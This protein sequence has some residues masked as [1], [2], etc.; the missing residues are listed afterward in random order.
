MKSLRNVSPMMV[1]AAALAFVLTLAVP[2]AAPAQESPIKIGPPSPLKLPSPRHFQL[3]NGLKVVLMENHKV[4]LV[5]VEVLVRGGSVLDPAGRAGLAT[6]TA[7]MMEEGAGGRSSLEYADAVDFLG[8]SISPYAS[9]HTSGVSLFTPLSKLDSAMALFADMVLR[10]SFPEQELERLRNERLTTLVQ[11][12]D[13]PRAIASVEFNQDLYGKD[14][15]YGRTSIG[16][17]ASIRAISVADLRSFHKKI[18]TPANATVIVVGDIGVDAARN[19]LEQYFGTWEGRAPEIPA[20]SPAPQVV[21]RKIILVDK[22]GAAQS[23]IRIGRIGTDRLTPDYFPLLVMNTILGGSFSSR[24]NQNL[25]ERNGYTYG[26]GSGFD[27]R[28]SAGPFRAASAVQ[29]DVTDKALVEFMKELTAIREPVSDDELTRA[30]NYLALLYPNNFET[31]S[32]AAGQLAELTVY[33]LPDDSFNTYVSSVMA[34]TKEDVLRVARKY[35]DPDNIAIVVVGDRQKVG[36]G[37][38]ALG[39]GP[40]TDMTIDDVLGPAPATGGGR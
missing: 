30:K 2:S 19:I 36:A 28:L 27:F 24:L 32:E 6:M 7:E 29:T 23:E 5:E 39:L 21:S 15:P 35:I 33:G 10:P 4:P 13:Q 11:W 12:H 17:E 38:S 14:H 34:V 37:I 3:G 16:D 1:V 22:P 8:A 26:A 31:I 9:T 20:L 18:F 40:V 25:R